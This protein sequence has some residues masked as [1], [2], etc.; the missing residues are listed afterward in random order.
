MTNNQTLSLEPY[1]AIALSSLNKGESLLENI[2]LSIPELQPRKVDKPIVLYGAGNLGKMAK[3]FFD[4]L[5]IPF[6]YVVDRNAEEHKTDGYWQGTRIIHPDYVDA[7]D[8]KNVLLVICIVTTPLIA[9][10]D[11]LIAAGW[12]D[13]AF[14]YDVS[15]AYSN[16][17]PISNGW[18]L[19]KPSDID[20]E[21]IRKVYS[22]I[23]D[24][25][26]HMYYLQFLAWHTHRTELLFSEI[27]INT[28]NRF[29]IPEV[30]SILNSYEVFID[31]GAHKGFVT[32]RFLKTVK[33]TYK[34]IYAIE[35]DNENIE[36]CK[37]VLNGTKD[38]MIMRY[39][40]SDRNGEENF[41]QGFDFASKLS[42]SGNTKVK[43]I[44]LDRLNI[45]AT[46]IKMH[47]E[48]GELSALKGALHTIQKYRPVMAITIYHNFDGVWRIPLFLME[49][50]KDY[51]YYMRLHS[52]GGTGAVLYAI[53]KERYKNGTGEY[54]NIMGG[55]A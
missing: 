44:S 37:L 45:P 49:N 47:L 28:S 17:H 42:N 36:S 27:E 55:F 50:A 51:K 46:F 14:F 26:S 29:F 16:R 1:T 2:L 38:I 18:F 19:S 4:Y 23:N 15:E 25:V 24:S 9:L 13:I 6:L 10:R 39:A 33:S 41:Y 5:N 32:E 20:K 21:L 34:N 31:C 12:K 53:P 48:G 30:V 35:P 40:L 54:K 8:K 52:W 43:T 7:A 3:G 11:E 22:S